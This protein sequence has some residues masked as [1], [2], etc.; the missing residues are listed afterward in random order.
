MPAANFITKDLYKNNDEVESIQLML[1]FIFI[2]T[3]YLN[4]NFP[5]GFWGFG[6]LGF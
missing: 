3:Y 5:M 1:K 4:K 6:V 2:L